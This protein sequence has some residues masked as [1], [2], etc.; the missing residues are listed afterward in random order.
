MS[1]EESVGTRQNQNP[2]SVDFG[3]WLYLFLKFYILE[4]NRADEFLI[5]VGKSIFALLR[6]KRLGTSL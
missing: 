3:D 2:E 6:V 4:G 1:Y 5:S